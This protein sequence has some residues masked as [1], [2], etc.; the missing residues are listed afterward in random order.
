MEQN[1][2]DGIETFDQ[3]KIAN[4]IND[5]STEIGPQVTSSMSTSFKD[6]K[7]FMNVSETVFQGYS[8][9]ELGEVVNG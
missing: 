1:G 9:E 8:Q 3:N 4:G 2:T 7:Q 5:F 6:F